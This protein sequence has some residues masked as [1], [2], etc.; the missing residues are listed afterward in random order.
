MKIH[1]DIE[2]MLVLHHKVEDGK[3]RAN[4]VQ[5]TLDMFL[6]RNKS[7]ILNVANGLNYSVL[8]FTMFS[9]P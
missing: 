8:K 1:Q 7:V 5:T 6:Q 2:K 4:T 3:K 9:F